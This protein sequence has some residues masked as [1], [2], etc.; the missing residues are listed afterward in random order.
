MKKIFVIL[1][2]ML[3]FFTTGCMKYSYNI[4]IDN[5]DNISVSEIGAIN[6]N[7]IKSFNPNAAAQMKSKLEE[8]KKEAEKDGFKAE[9]YDDGTYVGIKRMK[10]YKISLYEIKDLPKGFTTTQANPI[11]TD[12]KLFKTI[13]TINLNY[14]INNAGDD[15]NDFSGM[16]TPQSNNTFN[17]GNNFTNNMQNV[18]NIDGMP[19]SVP[20][21][22]EDRVISQEKT[23]DPTTGMT[24]E[25]TKY[26]SGA[27]S[28]ATYNQQETQ[29][30]NNAMESMMSSNPNMAPVA[31]LTIKLPKKAKEHNANEETQNFEY[32]WNLVSKEP[33]TIKLVYEKANGLN[34]FLTICFGLIGIICLLALVGDANKNV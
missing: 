17:E 30:F 21:S 1:S 9:V 31:D 19:N 26:A 10:D 18:Q 20:M 5:K 11:V 32:K 29:N 3:A 28:S 12:K 27:T 34:I 33:I 13:Y 6:M 2:C 14:D 8:D 24:T 15:N 7:F 16:Q 4:E 23:T 22:E 25:T